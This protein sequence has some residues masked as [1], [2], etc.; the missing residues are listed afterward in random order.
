M[1]HSDEVKARMWV[2]WS[3]QEGFIGDNKTQDLLQ[4]KDAMNVQKEVSE[5]SM[6][7]SNTCEQ[8]QVEDNYTRVDEPVDGQ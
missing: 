7:D 8:V 6:N 3:L 4:V 5:P 1:Q 2:D